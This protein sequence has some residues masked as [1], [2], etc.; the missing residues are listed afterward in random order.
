MNYAS[1]VYGILVIIIVTDWLVRGRR[2]YRGQAL[3][4]EEAEARLAGGE[5]V[6]R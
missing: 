2:H 4:H 5:A 6:V 3:R 1:A